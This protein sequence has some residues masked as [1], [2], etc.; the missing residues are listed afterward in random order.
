MIKLGKTLPASKPGLN[1]PLGE[2][3]NSRTRTTEWRILCGAYLVVAVVYV[4]YYPIMLLL[5]V[6]SDWFILQEAT[7]ALTSY[8]LYMALLV[9]PL[10]SMLAIVLFGHVRAERVP[11]KRIPRSAVL[12]ALLGVSLIVYVLGW[13]Q[14]AINFRGLFNRLHRTEIPYFS[15]QAWVVGVMVAQT[16]TFAVIYYWK[17]LEWRIRVLGVCL[18]GV[19]FFTDFILLG[20]RRFALPVI[21]FIVYRDNV[22][23]SPWRNWG[24]C[25]F[26]IVG[27]F[28]LFFFGG[29]RE[30]V[31]SGDERYITTGNVVALTSESNEFQEVGNG[32]DNVTRFAEVSGFSYGS[33]YLMAP[34]IF[35]PRKMWIEKPISLTFITGGMISPFSEAYLNFGPYG[36]LIICLGVGAVAFV[37]VGGRDSFVSCCVFAFVFDQMRTG[38][39]ELIYTTVVIA[40]IYWLCKQ[41]APAVTR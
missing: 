19:I 10:V 12:I 20:G 18:I 11:V 21:L 30:F 38:F 35:I 15:S 13:L 6:P 14:I 36:L 16:V 32:I 29:L 1:P 34:S 31:V 5:S 39:A 28:A 23:V 17:S 27:G 9:L 2:V 8:G 24:R 40:A 3:K 25:V 37:A 41:R 33:T 4:Y 7:G 26:L 22:L